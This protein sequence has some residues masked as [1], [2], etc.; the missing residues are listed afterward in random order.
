[1][2]LLFSHILL[3]FGR[4]LHDRFTTGGRHEGK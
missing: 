1:M 4:W 2:A 3:D